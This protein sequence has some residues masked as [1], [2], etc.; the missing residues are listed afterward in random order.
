MGSSPYKT[1]NALFC[2]VTETIKYDKTSLFSY[3]LKLIQL[4]LFK[5]G[6]ADSVFCHLLLKYTFREVAD[7]RI[8]M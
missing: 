2:D 3:I 7:Y 1:L 8:N 6:F 4:K 5:D